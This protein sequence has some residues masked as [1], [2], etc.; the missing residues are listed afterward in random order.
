MN[1]LF[2][3][4]LA[5]WCL[6]PVL[7]V[8][9]VLVLKKK[10]KKKRKSGKAG[11][12]GKA[13]GLASTEAGLKSTAKKGMPSAQSPSTAGAPGTPVLSKSNEQRAAAE[14]EMNK[15]LDEKSKSHPIEQSKEK[16]EKPAA[17]PRMFIPAMP[18]EGDPT[19]T[20]TEDEGT[21]A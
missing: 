9:L 21:K 3:A 13:G 19:R 16:P 4:S 15:L 5:L 18:N 1:T 14:Q 6:F 12:A 7:A 10:K 20:Q 11:K 2:L 17:N 8:V